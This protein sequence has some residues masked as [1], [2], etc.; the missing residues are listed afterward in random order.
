MFQ[1]TPLAPLARLPPMKAA[2]LPH[3]DISGSKPSQRLPEAFR[4]FLA[5]FIASRCQGIHRKP[6]QA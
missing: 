3:S 1:F 6:L 4:S 5:S 2:G